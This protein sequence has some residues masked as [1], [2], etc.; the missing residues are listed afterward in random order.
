MVLLVRKQSPK[1][2]II[3]IALIFAGA[4]GNIIDSIFYGVIFSESTRNGPVATLFPAGGGYS[5][6]FHGK[7]VDMIVIHIFTID[8]MPS[9]IPFIGGGPF[10]FFGPIFNIADA[11]ITIGVILIVIFQKSFFK[12]EDEE[13]AKL[14]VKSAGQI[15]HDVQPID[16]GLEPPTSMQ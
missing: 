11:A 15:H 7:V 16:Q 9:W 5:T 6:W 3:S 10:V 13:D 14:E 1:G 8:R 12:E 4:I 2:L